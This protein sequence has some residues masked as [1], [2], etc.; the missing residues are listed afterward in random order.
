[1]AYHCGFLVTNIDFRKGPSRMAQS[2]LVSDHHLRT[3]LRMK[4]F[5]TL[6]LSGVVSFFWAADS[7]AHAEMLHFSWAPDPVVLRADGP[8]SGAV[9]F[10]H[11]HANLTL[12][13][14][15][16]TWTGIASE[17]RTVSSASPGHPDTFINRPYSLTLTIT[18]DHHHLL[19]PPITFSGV[20]NGTL[21]HNSAQLSNTFTSSQTQTFFDGNLIVTIG[22]Y[23][24]PGPPGHHREGSIGT[25]VVVKG[26]LPPP[27]SELPEPST[28]VLLSLGAVLLGYTTWRKRNIKRAHRDVAAISLLMLVKGNRPRIQ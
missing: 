23:T 6:L 19:V 10:S 12:T 1:M 15:G 17:L 25:E 27:V 9:I 22:P 8:G 24:P 13:D 11:E 5:L 16:G 7:S 14:Q 3:S 4:R 18:D 2:I 28:M 26:P 20:L 21:S